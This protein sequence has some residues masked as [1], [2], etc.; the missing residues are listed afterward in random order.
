MKILKGRFQIRDISLAGM[1]VLRRILTCFDIK[2]N[3][4]SLC[5]CDIE[6]LIS[7]NTRNFRTVCVTA[8]V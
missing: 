7:T 5:E 4:Y 3:D 6:H 2:L 1:I 8:G